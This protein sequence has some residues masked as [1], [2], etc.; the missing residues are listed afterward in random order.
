MFKYGSVLKNK[1][2]VIYTNHLKEKISEPLQP[3]EYNKKVSFS[4]PMPLITRGLEVLSLV[5]PDAANIE[6]SNIL[7]TPIIPQ[8][9]K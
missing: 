9:A 8:K 4:L 2:T 7:N 6:I 1:Q 3:I 5:S